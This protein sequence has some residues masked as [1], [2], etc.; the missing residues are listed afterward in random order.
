MVSYLKT[1]VLFAS[2]A[3]ATYDNNLNYGSP[4]RRHPSLS[5]DVFKVAKRGLQARA[6]YEPSHLSFTHGVASGDPYPDSII[7]WTR[8]S[9]VLENDRSNVTVSGN[10]PLY[11][12]GTEQ[13]IKAST[14]PICVQYRV[15]TDKNLSSIVDRGTAYTTSDIDYTIKVD[16]ICRSQ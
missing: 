6:A 4:S 1:A 2:V 8:I 9:P 7:I 11:N 15:A 5:I 13:Y 3:L 16:S 12:H 10:V 14:N